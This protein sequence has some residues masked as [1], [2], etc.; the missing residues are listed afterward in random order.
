VSKKPVLALFHRASLVASIAERF[1]NVRLATFD[2]S[3][4]EPA[5]REQVARGIDWLRAPSFDPATI[6]AALKPWSA[7]EMTR[8]Q[9]AI[10]DRVSMPSALPD[11]LSKARPHPL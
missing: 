9:C 11:A 7:E 10:F 6:D 4:A 3:P 5:F 8:R 1:P 2:E